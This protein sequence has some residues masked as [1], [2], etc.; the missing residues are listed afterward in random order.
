MPPLDNN[1]FTLYIVWYR[2]GFLFQFF[3]NLHEY[4]RLFYL[5]LK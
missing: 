2:E 3:L 5:L 4:Q 1:L